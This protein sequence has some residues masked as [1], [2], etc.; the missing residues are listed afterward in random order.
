M[1]ILVKAVAGS[2]LFG[3]NTPTSDKDFKGVYLP[4]AREILIGNYKDTR[5]SS[6]GDDNLK[7]SKD[8]VDVEF[9]SFKKFLKMLEKGDTAALELLFTPEEF[10]LE[11]S[12]LWKE[13]RGDRGFFLSSQ[14][15]AMVGYARQQANKYG[16]KGSRMGELSKCITV[17]KEVQKGFDFQGAKLKHAWYE[18][19]EALKDFDHIHFIQ[20]DTTKGMGGPLTPAMDILGKKFDY[21]CNFIYVLE[22][23]KKIYKNYGHRARE[24]KNN[25]GIDWKALSHAVRVSIQGVELLETNH[26]TLPLKESDRKLVTD[27]KQGLI[28]YKEVA[29]LIESNLIDLERARLSS[30]LPAKLNR[31]KLDDVLA[32]IHLGVINGSY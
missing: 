15:S 8:D 28:D 16:I 4:E 14:V 32:R 21:H 7:N 12:R 1:K 27:I 31:H 29:V 25:N 18:I 3:T 30:S 13:L 19:Q 20:L 5:R 22:I 10:I 2:H 23:L 17:L 26:I 11:Q 6:T 9:Y 24:A